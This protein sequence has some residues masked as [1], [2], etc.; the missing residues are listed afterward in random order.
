MKKKLLFAAYSLDIGGIETA[1]VTLINYLVQEN[2]EVTLVLEK[3]QGIFLDE[4]S[5]KVNIIEYTPSYNKNKI[6]AK[7]KNA[8][9]R[10]KFIIK[11]KNKFDCGISYATYSLSSS[12]AARIASKNSVLWVHSE[13]LSMY[14]NNEN[15]YKDFFVNIKYDKFRKIIFVSNSAKQNF[16]RI[17]KIS[18]NKLLTVNNM[19]DYK[20][21]VK[22]SNENI[23]DVKKEN[24]CT[25][26][27]VGRHTEEDKKV[28]RLLEAASILKR[29]HFEFRILVIGQ[30]KNTDE[31]RE[32]VAK[33]NLKE[34]V[35]FL[36]NKKNPY[37]YYKISDC[38][39]LTS[40]Y[41]G[42]PV[43]YTE[44]M[45]LG[46]PIITTNVSD[47]NE[48]INNRFGI[49]TEKSVNSIYNAMKTF[50]C[51]PF[52][53]SEIFDAELYNHKIQNNLKNIINN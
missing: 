19:I 16:G 51:Q 1:L 3:K 45:V 34:Q 32:Y 36:G 4:I 18:D 52:I 24:I 42:F 30:G 23:E 40:E 25:F 44:A 28:S 33:N 7:M 26:L 10:A 6:L 50:I 35:I 20:R 21:I 43:V 48:I 46:L 17:M 27:F 9:N 22:K 53:I 49:V 31:Y 2:Y 39:V 38:L 8:I 12:F 11:Y 15:Q 47:S 41:E 37:P 14:G 13:Y 5:N 29:N